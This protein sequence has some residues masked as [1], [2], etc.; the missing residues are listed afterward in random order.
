MSL[1]ELHSN[2]PY[3]RIAPYIGMS[4]TAKYGMRI[5]CPYCGTRKFSVYQNNSNLEEWYYCSQCKASGRVIS[6]AAER[7]DLS[8]LEAI[9]YLS[10][11]LE[12]KI[13]EASVN[14]Y[15][16]S[17]SIRESYKKF[18]DF[19][20][21]RMFNPTEEEIRYIKHLGWQPRTH[22]SHERTLNGPAKLYGLAS[23][24]DLHRI[25]GYKPRGSSLKATCAVIPLFQ[26]PDYL[27]DFIFYTTKGIFYTNSQAYTSVLKGDSGFAGIQF[28]NEFQ[29]D[30]LVITP[31]IRNMIQMNMRH[32]SSNLNPLPMLGYYQ[33][34]TFNNQKQWTLIEDRE[35]IIW[36]KSPSAVT[37][38]QAMLSNAKMSFVGPFQKN[39][40]KEENNRW[41]KWIRVTPAIDIWKQIKLHARNYEHATK[42]WARIATDKQKVSLLKEAENYNSE[43]ASFVRSVV[44]PKIA[45]SVGKRIRVKR[46][47]SGNYTILVEKNGKWYDRKGRLRFPG[48]V[49]VS[50]VVLRPSGQKEYIGKVVIKEKEI[51]FRTPEGNTDLEWLRTLCLRNGV[52]VTEQQYIDKSQDQSL[53][54]INPI[55]AALKLEEPTAVVGLEKIGWDGSGFQL[56]N[57]RISKGVFHE[58]NKYE[59]PETSPGPEQLCCRMRKEVVEALSIDNKEMEICWAFAAAVCTQLITPAVNILTPG[60][61][62]KGTNEAFYEVLL[63]RAKISTDDNPDWPHKWPRAIKGIRLQREKSGFFVMKLSDKKKMPSHTIVVNMAEKTLQ[64]RLVSDSLD[65]IVLNYL[66][67]FSLS[68]PQNLHS[69][70][71]ALT[72]VTEKIQSIFGVN[73]KAIGSF[74]ARLSYVS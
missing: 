3:F 18:W 43:V 32:F 8:E 17:V 66:K 26:T 27:S 50:H 7:L 64:P 15:V 22:M 5:E 9:E 56:K 68:Q 10:Q 11:K 21:K 48:I 70:D 24:K 46:T 55:D 29:S 40:D 45:S 65:K 52:I 49:R 1:L 57:A 59:M 25:T 28:L 69:V 30:T 23:I 58:N 54:R 14:D 19:A 51:P 67:D 36:E 72:Y 42:N 39:L 73:S 6:M 71:Q 4:T 74:P 63:N 16:K 2:L 31:M 20:R 44:C 41:K 13:D 62:L 33:P 47:S 38:H 12:N 35:L 34:N 61:V 60:I 53:D 37:L